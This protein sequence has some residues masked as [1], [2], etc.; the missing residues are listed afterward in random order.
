MRNFL[1][2]CLLFAVPVIILAQQT[3][4]LKISEIH[5]DLNGTEYKPDDLAEVTLS[6]HAPTSVI[7]FEKDRVKYG[8]EFQYK[9]GRNRIKLVRK[10]WV[11]KGGAEPQK[12]KQRKDMQELKTSIT[13]SFSK[14]V[15][16][17]IIIDRTNLEAI[18]VSFRYELIY[19]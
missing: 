18:N 19:K 3:A 1:L 13:G 15:V 16:D 14:R 4:T 11:I 9:K 6:D 12:G 17:N 10:G 2:F 8:V 7:V 5:V